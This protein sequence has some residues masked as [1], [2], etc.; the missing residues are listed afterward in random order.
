MTQIF[1]ISKSGENVL[2][3]TDPND[4]IFHSSFNTFKII[5]EIFTNIEIPGN[6]NATYSI[7]HGLSYIPSCNAFSQAPSGKVYALGTFTTNFHDKYYLYSIHA[8]STNVYISV[9]SND[10]GAIDMDFKIYLF[11]TPL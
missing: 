2:T 11:E 10:A 7:A 5:A 1:A 4:F 9:D 6:S 3:A 8:D